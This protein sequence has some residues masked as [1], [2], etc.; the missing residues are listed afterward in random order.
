M[1]I[2]ICNRWCGY[3]A[4]HRQ[5]GQGIRF[6]MAFARLGAKILSEL[7]SICFFAMYLGDS[8]YSCDYANRINT[9]YWKGQ[10]RLNHGPPIAQYVFPVQT[11]FGSLEEF[12]HMLHEYL[13]DAKH[14]KRVITIFDEVCNNINE[15]DSARFLKALINIRVTAPSKRSFLCTRR[16]L[17]TCLIGWCNARTIRL[18]QLSVSS[19]Q[20]D[21]A[22]WFGC[23]KYVIWIVIWI[24]HWLLFMSGDGS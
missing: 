6:E 10:V 3:I 22:F 23:V 4:A 17:A 21:R 24:D 20:V 16:S 14:K 2:L 12:L 9:C 15:T 8:F 1:A 19:Y 13:T 11:V 7:V 5:E 18:F